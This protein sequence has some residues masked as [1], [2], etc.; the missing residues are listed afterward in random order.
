[1]TTWKF[2]MLQN[3]LET[4]KSERKKEMLNWFLLHEC[5]LNIDFWMTE[6][7]SW[8]AR[9]RWCEMI[10][11]VNRLRTQP[12]WK[13]CGCHW[14]VTRMPSMQRGR[15][16]SSQSKGLPIEVI[17]L[18]YLNYTKIKENGNR[19]VKRDALMCFLFSFFYCTTLVDKTVTIL[20]FCF[21]Q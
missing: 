15:N 1:M 5:I 12:W 11:S 20:K 16:I 6:S 18:T 3:R 2:I 10:F 14:R 13:P 21:S 9:T 17:I 8:S 7:R 19:I 4:A